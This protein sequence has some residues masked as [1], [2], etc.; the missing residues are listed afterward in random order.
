MI[1]TATSCL[2]Q[3]T[4]RSFLDV[5]F[6]GSFFASGGY[7]YNYQRFGGAD[8]LTINVPQGNKWTQSGLV[9]ITKVVSLKTKFFKKTKVQLLWDF[10]SYQHQ[11]RTQELKFRV[12]YNF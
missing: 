1:K 6:M 5:K 7:E 12:G 3:K 8:S 4:F 10:L 2:K 11:P 9:G